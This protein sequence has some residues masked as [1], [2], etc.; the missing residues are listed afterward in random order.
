MSI[1]Y[2]SCARN[3]VA[4]F[5]I[6]NPK[7]SLQRKSGFIFEWFS[8]KLHKTKL[9]DYMIVCYIVMLKTGFK[10]RKPLRPRYS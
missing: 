1:L 8:Y 6:I 2:A 7:R 5:Y 9:S 4:L 10:M 3:P